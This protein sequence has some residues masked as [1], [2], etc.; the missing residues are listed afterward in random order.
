MTSIPP[1]VIIESSLDQSY[2]ICA[3]PGFSLEVT[4]HDKGSIRVRIKRDD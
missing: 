1:P 2:W 3:R 4:Y